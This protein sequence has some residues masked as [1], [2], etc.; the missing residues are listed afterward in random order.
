MKRI[1]SI[2]SHV[3][4]G[5]VGNRAAVFPLQRLGHDVIAI[6]TVEFS[7]HTGYGQWEGQIFSR[8]FIEKIVLGVR[9]VGGLSGVE[10]LLT[11]YLGSKEI[12]DGITAILGDLPRG[13]TWLCDPVMGDVGR[14]FFVSEEIR[15]FFKY[16]IAGIPKIMTPNLFELEFL[17]DR[18][19]ENLSDARAACDVLHSKGTEIILLTSMIVRETPQEKISMLAS[20][21]S[22]E[23]YI[24]TTPR[25][26]L[27]PAPNG[28]GDCTAA[29]FLSNLLNG[30][31]LDDALARTA[32]S[33]FSV[34][35]ETQK[36]GSRELALIK[37]QDGFVQPAALK[38]EKL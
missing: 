28:A 2:Q 12:G 21:Q 7:N 13:C 25:L 30:Y 35:A 9:D 31:S 17:S 1:L 22:G 18:K 36:A 5:Y 38:A 19:I 24:V 15:N 27:D 37:A 4:Y 20:S 6:N 3:A 23:Q 11:G 34:F 33:M 16:D 8:A 26:P 32:A 14:G 10:A 29:L